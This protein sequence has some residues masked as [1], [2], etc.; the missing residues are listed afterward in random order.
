[1]DFRLDG[2][3]TVAVN[4]VLPLVSVSVDA[5]PYCANAFETDMVLDG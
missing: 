4:V 5:I 3:P 2:V 1:M